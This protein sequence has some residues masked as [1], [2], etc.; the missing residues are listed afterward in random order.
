MYDNESK[1]GIKIYTVIFLIL[2]T[3]FIGFLV[4]KG[5]DDKNFKNSSIKKTSQVK[6]VR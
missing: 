3:G 4:S 2:L 5:I 6:A 1:T